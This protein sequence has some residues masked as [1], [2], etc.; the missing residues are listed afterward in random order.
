LHLFRSDVF[1]LLRHIRF[2][3]RHVGAMTDGHADSDLW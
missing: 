2:I 3:L 1:C